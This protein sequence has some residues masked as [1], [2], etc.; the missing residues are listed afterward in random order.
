LISADSEILE[1]K[2]S[3]RICIS[4]Y[5]HNLQTLKKNFARALK[6][7]PSY[8]ELRLDYLEDAI[9]CAP[10]LDDLGRDERQIFTFRARSEGGAA[11]IS[12]KARKTLLLELLSKVA[13]AT[14]DI[15]IRTLELFP[16]LLD[17]TQ[18]SGTRLIVSSHDFAGTGK[19]S[20]LERLI[21]LSVRKYTPAVVKIVRGANRFDDNITL[22][23]LY[24]ISEKIRPTKLVAFCVGPLGIFSRL[25]CI[26]CGSPFTFASLPGKRT[27]P[28]QLDAE[29]MISLLSSWGSRKILP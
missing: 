7:E 18:A 10:K 16:E 13:P 27:A 29:S 8:V 28:G 22:L 14:V 2:G 15:E 9:N 3:K 24:R 17:S 25:A 1:T 12:D 19:Q 20:D 23:S 11:R 26:G 4:V 6:F 21:V 5:G